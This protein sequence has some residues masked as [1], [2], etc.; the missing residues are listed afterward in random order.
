MGNFPRT[1]LQ[2]ST[3]ICLRQ[4]CRKVWWVCGIT[5]SYTGFL[6]PTNEPPAP[7]EAASLREIQVTP[8]PPAIPWL[9]SC[10]RDV[11][12][13]V[14]STEIA[15]R[16]TCIV[17]LSGCISPEERLWSKSR[18][19]PQT[20]FSSGCPKIISCQSDLAFK[21][22][23]HLTSLEFAYFSFICSWF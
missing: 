2:G 22:S 19:L 16:W 23:F 10:F 4:D 7:N 12:S 14:Q 21:V 18:I 11:L 13:Q 6:A 9:T 3:N 5:V 20:S 1:L 17:S 15:S 8:V